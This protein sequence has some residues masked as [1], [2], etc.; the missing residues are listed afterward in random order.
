M[1]I[2]PLQ[3]LPM[4]QDEY[5]A[6]YEHALTEYAAEHA[7]TGGMSSEEALARSRREFKD[8][9]PEGVHSSGQHLYSVYD[10][11][12]P[13]SVGMI[14]FAERGGPPATQAYIYDVEIWEEFRG[15]GYGRGVMLAVENEVRALGLRRI[16]L[17]V[18]GH[19]TTAI[20][21]YETTGY[22]T[23]NIIMAKELD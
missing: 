14:W 2:P 15:R 1:P 13:R 5:L 10:P 3:L 19:N 17:H 22:R 20:R 6:W 23:T 9:L 8:L 21:L 16:G 7:A 4:R 11:E 12:E 18:F